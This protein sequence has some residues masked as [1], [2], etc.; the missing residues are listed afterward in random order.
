MCGVHDVLI[1]TKDI[2]RSHIIHIKPAKFFRVFVLKFPLH[3]AVRSWLAF[4]LLPAHN[5]VFCLLHT[6][7]IDYINLFSSLSVTFV[8]SCVNKLHTKLWLAVCSIF[9][10]VRIIR[11]CLLPK[12]TVKCRTLLEPWYSCPDYNTL[13]IG[14]L[15]HC[16]QIV[17]PKIGLIVR[18]IF[19]GLLCI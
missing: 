18:I 17:P 10:A 19:S 16:L 1:T 9:Y 4:T 5:G 6:K 13:G 8:I 7:M 15:L 14:V 11:I 2:H 3:E 12:V